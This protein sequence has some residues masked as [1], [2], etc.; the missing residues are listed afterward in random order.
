MFMSLPARL[1]LR[2]LFYVSLALIE[3]CLTTAVNRYDTRLY[4]ASHK[5]YGG[6]T[7]LLSKEKGDKIEGKAS[8]L[9]VL[10]YYVSM[11]SKIF[12]SA[13]PHNRHSA[14]VYSASQMMQMIILLITGTYKDGGYFAP[15]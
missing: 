15:S 2:N 4:L 14:L 11:Q 3:V 13:S 7:R 10:D 1:S 6:K 12:I 9:A 5:V 8:L